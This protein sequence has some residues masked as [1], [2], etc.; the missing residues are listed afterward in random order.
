MKKV[1]VLLATVV[2]A[3]F[4]ATDAHAGRFGIKG[5]MNLANTDFKTAPTVGY[6]L[7]I[8]WQWNLPLWLAIQPDLLYSVKG[9]TGADVQGNLAT[10]HLKL[11]V[12]VQWGPRLAK[13]NIRIFAQASPYVQYAVTKEQS[14][15]WDDV[16]RFE[17]GA[18]VGAGIQLWCFQ[19]TAQYNWH[20]GALDNVNGTKLEN[21]NK[22]NAS[23]ASVSLAL[24]FG[25]KKK[26]NK[27]QTQQK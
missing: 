27:T 9:A 21:F 18:G 24:M 4:I 11:P 23:G 19:L 13:K 14:A 16:N 15:S 25:K 1:V 7:G 17:C 20:I 10:G 12:N 26:N 6:D 8:T 22:A 5:S 3:A 2:L